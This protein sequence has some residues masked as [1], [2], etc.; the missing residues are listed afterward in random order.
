MAEQIYKGRAPREDYGQLMSFL[1]QVFFTR[2][3]PATKRD[4]LSLLPKLYKEEY[5]P[6]SNNI[7]I[8]EGD[9]IKAA[10]GLFYDKIMA[11][12]QELR[13]GGIGIESQGRVIRILRW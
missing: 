12:G 1:D 6:C 2:D 13:C 5:D 7:V 4:F 9:T 8:K 11:G 3:D 10:V